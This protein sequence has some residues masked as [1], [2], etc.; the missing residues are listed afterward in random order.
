MCCVLAWAVQR[1]KQ[2][3]LYHT[4]WLIARLD[5]IKYIFKKPSLS[6]RITRWQVLL[7]EFDIVYVSQKAI[8][9]S[10]IADF[11]AERASEEYEPM[12]FDF[13]DE[14]LMAVLQIDEE[15][16]PEEDGWKM[17]FDRVSNALGRGVGAVLISSK[18]N[19][20]PFTAKLS[21]E[22]TNNVT[23]YEACVLGLQVVI[24]KKIKSLNVYGDSAL[25][26]CQ[27][28]GEWETRDSKLVPYQDFIKKLIEQFKDITFKHLPRE[29]NYLANALATLATM[30]KV[31]ANA[32]A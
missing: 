2:Y 10:A 21:F 27:L 8:K 31:N 3:M 13:L 12:S 5:P 29:E 16:T 26:I 20:C 22:C 17:Y 28:N 25:V 14:D 4:T 18:G 19:H 1:L 9:G 32:D 15:K 6:G 11:L 23:E 24:E 7:S 30:F